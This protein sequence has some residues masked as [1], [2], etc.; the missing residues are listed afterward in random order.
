M[1]NPPQGVNTTGWG[2]MEAGA[3]MLYP[4]QVI[5]G[6]VHIEGG[7]ELQSALDIAAPTQDDNGMRCAVG[8]GVITDAT[9]RLHSIAQYQ[10]VIHVVPPY[11]SSPRWR[12]E[13]IQCYS[14][15]LSL[16][17]NSA[18]YDKHV[19]LACP[20]IG[21]GARGAPWDEAAEVAVEA[22]TT[23]SNSTDES[24]AESCLLTHVRMVVQAMPR[25][26]RLINH[27]E[28]QAWKRVPLS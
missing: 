19:V 1:H 4:T 18:K 24:C 11:Y 13:L 21:S 16:S 14:A 3:G 8:H 26:S 23:W 27:F 2:G 25:A 28:Q 17:M 9:S 22:L 10:Q 20:I 12:A 15:A 7:E 6:R 5:D